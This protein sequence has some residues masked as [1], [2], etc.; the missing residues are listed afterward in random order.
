MINDRQKRPAPNS[1]Y[2]KAAVQWLNEPNSCRDCASYQVQWW[3]T[4]VASK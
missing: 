1:F 4:V 3:Q 2:P